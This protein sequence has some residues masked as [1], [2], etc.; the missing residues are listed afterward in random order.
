[1]ASGTFILGSTVQAR[2]PPQRDGYGLDASVVT[3]SRE[4]EL[5][6]SEE[7]ALHFSG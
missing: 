2:I 6:I 1:M 3:L 5:E 7:R 4:L